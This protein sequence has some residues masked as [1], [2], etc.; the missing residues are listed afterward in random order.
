MCM[1]IL[2]NNPIAHIPILA[3]IYIQLSYKIANWLAT[4]ISVKTDHPGKQPHPSQ[5]PKEF[6]HKATS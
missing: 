5:H 2:Y 6:T 1:S 4:P 3:I